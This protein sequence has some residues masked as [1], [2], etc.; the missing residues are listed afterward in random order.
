MLILGAAIAVVV[1]ALGNLIL[2]F[3]KLGPAESSP[4]GQS[5]LPSLVSL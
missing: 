1:I 5:S 3:M 4:T 2:N